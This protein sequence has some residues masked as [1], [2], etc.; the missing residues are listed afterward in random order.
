[1]ITKKHV[2][3]FILS[4]L[5]VF[6]FIQM[7]D[8]D[9]QLISETIIPY[10]NHCSM[11]APKIDTTQVIWYSVYTPDELGG[12]LQDSANAITAINST[13]VTPDAQDGPKENNGKNKDN[14]GKH[15]GNSQGGEHGL[16][17]S[18]RVGGEDHQGK[19]KGWDKKDKK[20]K[21]D[22][23]KNN[24]LD[25]DNPIDDNIF[26]VQEIDNE[27]TSEE[28]PGDNEEKEDKL[29]EESGEILEDLIINLE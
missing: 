21:K 25:F 7:A 8:A 27:I 16:G 28:Q 4:I 6:I 2:K 19:H 24:D 17:E 10:S 14:N 11:T 3:L 5:S 20:D 1:M 29:P 9:T 13:N 18:R 23:T 22:K 15:K 12:H 26:E